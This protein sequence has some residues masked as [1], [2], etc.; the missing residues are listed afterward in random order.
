M[1]GLS[2]NIVQVAN[3]LGLI[4][5]NGDIPASG[6]YNV[7]CP[8]C[9]DYKLNININKGVWRCAHCE[10]HG[11]TLSLYTRF[12]YGAQS[13]SKELGQ[14]A[15]ADI[16][17]RIGIKHLQFFSNDFVKDT[18]SLSDETLDNF[19][20]KLLEMPELKLN[21]DHKNKLKERGFSETDITMYQYRTLPTELHIKWNR[22]QIL[23]DFNK[24]NVSKLFEDYPNL[25][26]IGIKRILSG[27]VIGEYFTQ[28]LKMIPEDVPGFFKIGNYW[29]FNYFPGMLIPLR[30]WK[31]QIVGFQIYTGVPKYKYITLSSRGFDKG[32]SG[33]SRLHFS[34]LNAELN[35]NT[36]VY[37]TEGPLKADCSLSL[38]SNRKNIAFAALLGVNSLNDLKRV[39]PQLKE[40]KI[41][42]IVDTLDM[43]KCTNI[44][45]INAWEKIHRLITAQKIPCKRLFWDLDSVITCYNKQLELL[46]IKFE[47]KKS[48]FDEIAKKTIILN[49]KKIEFKKEWLNP[50]KKGIDDYLKSLKQMV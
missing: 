5:K 34:I 14:R 39:L 36:T 29:Y 27:I 43:D 8:I 24:N 21:D 45:V 42:A 19:Y 44:H 50:Q 25:K 47:N 9:G 15:L 18:T 6:S 33:G 12:A 7:K 20:S 3:L 1:A 10:E 32:V 11:G 13:Y 30:N 48:I 26:R 35:Q 38:I 46:D 37:L 17:Q 2:F 23:Q 31:H 16:E 22:F 49:D 40:M 41:K 28:K 4:P